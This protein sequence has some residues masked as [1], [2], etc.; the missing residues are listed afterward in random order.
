[1]NQDIFYLPFET[2]IYN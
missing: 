2:K 1:M